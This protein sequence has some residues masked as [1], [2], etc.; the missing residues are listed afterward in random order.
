MAK[1]T[2]KTEVAVETTPVSDVV[3][4]GEVG[5]VVPVATGSVDAVVFDKFESLNAKVTELSSTLRDLQV[6]LKSVQKEVVKLVKANVKKSKT[7]QTSVKKTPSG[8]AK[9]TKLSDV[10]CDFLGVA[11][12]T[13][14]ARTDV[15]RRLNAYIKENHLQDEKDKRKIHPDVKL[16][17]VLTVKEGDNL[18]FFNLQTA[19]KDNFIKAT[20]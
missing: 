6:Y 16:S 17:K 18:T 8:F 4:S 10:L 13:E 20:V 7:R 3:E 9:P 11:K 19:L 2:M 1:K 15:T 14:M 12:G 5:E